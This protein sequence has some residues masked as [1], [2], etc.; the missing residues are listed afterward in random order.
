MWKHES[1]Y[2]ESS[3]APYKSDISGPD[4]KQKN[5]KK[6]FCSMCGCALVDGY[7]YCPKCGKEVA[8]RKRENQCS[9]GAIFEPG[10]KF[11]FSCGKPI[12][13]KSK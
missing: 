3:I 13:Q 12:P 2:Y 8:E 10:E 9:C 5:A 4:K 7:K 11:C 6:I 1:P